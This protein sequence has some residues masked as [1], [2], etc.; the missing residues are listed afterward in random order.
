M[1]WY[2]KMWAWI[3]AAVKAVF[4][5]CKA[6]LETTE[7]NG[8]GLS[9]KRLFGLTCLIVAVILALR[10]GVDGTIIGLFLG[11][12]TGVFVTAAATGT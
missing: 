1:K 10:G 3:K 4:D 9:S 2:Q 11:A 8:G 6:A 5:W 7:K 12:A